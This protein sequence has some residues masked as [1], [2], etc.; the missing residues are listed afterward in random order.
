MQTGTGLY[1]W[2]P[3]ELDHIKKTREEVLIGMVEKRYEA[4]QKFL[5]VTYIH[6][7]SFEN[8]DYCK[9]GSPCSL[10]AICV[11]LARYF[12]YGRY[13]IVLLYFL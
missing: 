6:L 1:Q 10:F 11:Y 2:K 3:E 4:G 13:I 8:R 7:S 12:F 9:C 5:T